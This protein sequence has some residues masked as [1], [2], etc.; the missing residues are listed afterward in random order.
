MLLVSKYQI[1][2]PMFTLLGSQVWL[3]GKKL[4]YIQTAA[5]SYLP[6]YCVSPAESSS[7]HLWCCGSARLEILN[8]VRSWVW[9]DIDYRYEESKSIIDI[10][11]RFETY[12][13]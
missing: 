12:F 8:S 13:L 6:G 5:Y 11:S 7:I 1:I 10:V 2:G 9:I 4:D 3:G